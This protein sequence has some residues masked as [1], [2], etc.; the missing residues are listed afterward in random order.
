[1][2]T[3]SIKYN[4]E[5]KELTI[6]TSDSNFEFSEMFD[7]L[8]DLEIVQANEIKQNYIAFE[9]LVYEL[10]DLSISKLQINKK[11]TLPYIGTVKELADESF[12][13]WY[14]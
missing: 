5:N 7:L 4:Q 10:D 14:Y 8:G 6:N 9:G 12:I 2:N 3:F 1:M 13:N 11:I